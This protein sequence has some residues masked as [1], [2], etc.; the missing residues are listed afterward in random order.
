M[1]QE[2]VEKSRSYRRF[3]ENRQIPK[4]TLEGLIDVAE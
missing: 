2:L 3:Q 4:E 1:I